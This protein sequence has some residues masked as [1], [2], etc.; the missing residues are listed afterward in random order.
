MKGVLEVF[1]A[2]ESLLPEY[3]VFLYQI[4]ATQSSREVALLR[5]RSL[6]AMQ[7]ELIFS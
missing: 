3:A 5:Y 4:S 1:V 6:V 2:P 7:V